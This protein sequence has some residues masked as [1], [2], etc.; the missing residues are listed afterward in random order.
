MLVMLYQTILKSAKGYKM[1]HSI[2]IETINNLGFP[3]AVCIA[4][5]WLYREMIKNQNQLLSE[6]KDT[7]RDNTEMMRDSNELTKLLIRELNMTKQ[8]MK[9][10]L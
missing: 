3:V 9:N 2:I 1:E 5:F 8:V 4:L 10:D 6:F 7:I